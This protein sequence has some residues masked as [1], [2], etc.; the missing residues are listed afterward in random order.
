MARTGTAREEAAA[1]KVKH[2]EDPATEA[3]LREP[4]TAEA[5][6]GGGKDSETEEIRNSSGRERGKGLRR[7]TG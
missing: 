2:P 5:A 6:I 4:G 7:K 3:K 1:D